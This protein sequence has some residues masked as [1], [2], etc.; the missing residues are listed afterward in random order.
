MSRAAIDTLRFSNHL[1]EAGFTER[2]AEAFAQALEAELNG[3]A[4]AEAARERGT[5]TGEVRILKWAV[6]I[7]LAF[8]FGAFAILYRGQADIVA[9]QTDLRERVTRV[10][11]RMVRVE[12][13]LTG[14]EDRL[15]RVEER[16]TG[17]EDRMTRMEELL[18]TLVARQGGAS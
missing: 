5:L 10:E 16:L 7:A 4:K 11:E 18:R 13:R 15:T 14:L 12:E 8:I 6:G 9:D 1:K 17:L 2:Q 3:D